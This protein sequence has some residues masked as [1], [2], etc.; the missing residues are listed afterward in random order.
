MFV[1]AIGAHIN[2]KKMLYTQYPV[3]PLPPFLKQHGGIA[4]ADS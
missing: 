4:L 2:F 3:F 1:D